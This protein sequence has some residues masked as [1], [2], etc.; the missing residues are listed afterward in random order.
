MVA[1]WIALVAVVW[2]SLLPEMSLKGVV[3]PPFSIKVRIEPLTHFLGCI[4]LAWLYIKAYGM[5]WIGL[6]VLML[7]AGLSEGVQLFVED[8]G[9]SLDDLGFNILGVF[10][11]MVL[12]NL[13]AIGRW[14][15]CV[16]QGS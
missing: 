15:R 5:S 7:V 8:R 6:V 13:D 12:A 3:R 10:S 4:L 1:F 9:A 11:G 2:V 16:R 14:I